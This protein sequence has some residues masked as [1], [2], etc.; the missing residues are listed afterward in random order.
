VIEVLAVDAE[1]RS[2]ILARDGE[3]CVMCGSSDVENHFSR[4]ILEGA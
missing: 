4:Q 1:T 2:T 3:V